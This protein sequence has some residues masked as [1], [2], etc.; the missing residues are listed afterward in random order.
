MNKF[1]LQKSTF[2]FFI[3]VIL[4]FSCGKSNDNNNS[5]PKKITKQTIENSNT[6]QIL[7]NNNSD[8]SLAENKKSLS[9]ASDIN[10]VK[11]KAEKYNSSLDLMSLSDSNMLI[12]V[13]NA[14]NNGD[15]NEIASLFRVL[16]DSQDYAMALHLATNALANA[17]LPKEKAECVVM[18]LRSFLG[19]EDDNSNQ[20]VAD[21]ALNVLININDRLSEKY[22]TYFWESAI[23]E[24]SSI[25]QSKYKNIDKALQTIT[26][27]EKYLNKKKAEWHKET[28][29]RLIGHALAYSDDIEKYTMSNTTLKQL[30]KY[31]LSLDDAMIPE[32]IKGMPD[33]IDN[34]ERRLRPLLLKGLERY[35][36]MHEK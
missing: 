27:A 26:F 35:E 31:A 4:L 28:I 32:C 24:Y 9:E 12:Q 21:N 15:K 22:K 17:N 30:Q 5:Y 34:G 11:K 23:L 13:E 3:L 25:C 20:Q 8:L 33:N 16:I 2:C 29:Y 18:T 10:K 1:I 7:S 36:K 14:I 19:A 6:V